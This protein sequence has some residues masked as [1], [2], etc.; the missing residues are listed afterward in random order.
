[1]VLHASRSL[2]ARRYAQGDVMSGGQIAILGHW[3][4]AVGGLTLLLLL[5]AGVAVIVWLRRCYHNARALTGATQHATAWAIWGWI[6]PVVSLV[7][8]LLVVRD[9]F[10]RS[11]R[12]HEAAAPVPAAVGWW[13]GLVIGSLVAGAVAESTWPVIRSVVDLEHLEAAWA[14]VGVLRIAAGLVGIA[15]G[16]ELTRRQRRLLTAA[17][18]DQALRATS[19]TA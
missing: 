10:A 15:I 12:F 7:M 13:W 2:E 4:R 19:R 16:A 14:G 5:A 6:V 18:E 17:S 3:E 11:R 1:M 9:A 8:P